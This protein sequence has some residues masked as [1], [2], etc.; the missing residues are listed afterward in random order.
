MTR[1]DVLQLLPPGDFD[2]E[3]TT[4][5]DRR[6]RA[7]AAAALAAASWAVQWM[8][9]QPGARHVV[10]LHV[11]DH[12]T[13]RMLLGGLQRDALADVQRY[14]VAALSVLRSEPGCERLMVD[15][16]A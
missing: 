5:A 12:A 8:A 9:G 7:G 6:A 15:C 3:L 2:T 10:C 1:G 11:A 13:A 16:V 14:T 4:A